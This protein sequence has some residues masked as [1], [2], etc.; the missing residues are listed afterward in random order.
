MEIND[1]GFKP[2]KEATEFSTSLIKVGSTLKEARKK[3]G[4]SIQKLADSLRM[5]AEQIDAL[6]NG[7]QEYLP[8]L[9]F[10]KAMVRR[11]SDRLGIDATPLLEEL[12]SL[13]YHEPIDHRIVTENIKPVIHFRRVVQWTVISGVI[14]VIASGL[15]ISFLNGRPKREAIQETTTFNTQNNFSKNR[16]KEI[17]PE[18]HIINSSHPSRVVIRNKYGK[19]LFKGI[20]DK[21]I[22]FAKEMGVEIFAGRPELIFI[23]NKQNKA[24]KLGEANDIKW[25]T[26]NHIN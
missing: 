8:E 23:R 7:T 26:I 15:G 10:I 17:A 21:E 4:L 25:H 11:V 6:E 20:L 14:G 22:S 12:L 5:G 24:I 3:K 9:V 2:S 19:I 1:E 13:D 18:K 16:K